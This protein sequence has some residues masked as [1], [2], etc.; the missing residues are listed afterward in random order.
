MSDIHRRIAVYDLD[1]TLTAAPTFTPF[2]HFAAR[3][4]APWRVLLSPAWFALM[5]AY[6]A[7]LMDRTTLKRR[8]MRLMTGTVS[9][10]D[11]R[12][13]GREFAATRAFHPLAIREVESD[14]AGGAR[15]IVATAAFDFYA[16]GIAARLGL[17]DVI[18][19]RWDGQGIPGGNCYG[20][21]KLRRV[22]AWLAEQGL[23]RT[24]VHVRA[25]SDSFADAPLLD[26]ADEAWFVTAKGAQG[27]RAEARG[28]RAVDF[29]C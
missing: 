16:R 20:A 29:S 8:G 10:E 7:G 22:R 24:E 18:A 17:E 4:I 13:I 12:R 14:L 21:E 25:V 2:L 1:R 5:I 3:R 28:W 15:V 27:R 19:T 26:W 11:L 6:R 23:S 9:K